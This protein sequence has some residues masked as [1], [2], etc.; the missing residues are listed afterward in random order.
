MANKVKFGLKNVH[1]AKVTE[2][3]DPET[4][5]WTTTYGEVKAWP[6]AVNLSLSA[7]GDQTDFFADDINY[8]S[9]VAN[10]GYEGDYES[11]L[12]PEDVYISILGQSKDETTGLVTESADDVDSYV[13]LMFE[14]SGDKSK[15]R[16]VLYRVKFTRPN[17]DASTIESSKEVKTDSV[18]MKAT[19][20][21]DDGKIRAFANEGDGTAYAKFFE[22]VQVAA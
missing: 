10:Q 6:G 19:P 20:R 14:I 17:I 11:A 4:G 21:L 1:Y 13:A 8:E 5:K 7:A 3:L 18:S 16:F 22:S 15:R 9:S 12:I 2:T